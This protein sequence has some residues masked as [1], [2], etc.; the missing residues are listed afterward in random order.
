ML[1]ADHLLCAEFNSHDPDTQSNPYIRE[2]QQQAQL[3]HEVQQSMER[4]ATPG[5]GPS[6]GPLGLLTQG[7]THQEEPLF[8]HLVL[9]AIT[10]A[11]TSARL[12]HR[13]KQDDSHQPRQ[14]EHQTNKQRLDQRQEPAQGLGRLTMGARWYRLATFPHTSILFTPTTEMLLD[15]KARPCVNYD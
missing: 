8:R 13:T 3:Q 15:M 1:G 9:V 7:N 5:R 11:V 2:L 14:H 12:G 10:D 6:A 4:N